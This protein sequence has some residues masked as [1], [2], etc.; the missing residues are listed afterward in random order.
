MWVLI[1]CFTHSRRLKL[2]YLLTLKP[3]GLHQVSSAGKEN[4]QYSSHVGA[5]EWHKLLLSDDIL[6]QNYLIVI[7]KLLCAAD[8]IVIYQHHANAPFERA[9]NSQSLHS[10]LWY[11]APVLVQTLLEPLS[12]LVW[13][14]G[15]EILL[16]SDWDLVTPGPGCKQFRR[17]GI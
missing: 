16:T 8:I 3:C 4:R 6:S 14:I 2:H 15:E 12:L 7:L 13:V 1:V 11:E 17:A 5:A 9:T 10:L